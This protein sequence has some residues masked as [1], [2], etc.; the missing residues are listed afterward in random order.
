M[1]MKENSCLIKDNMNWFYSILKS[2]GTKEKEISN[3]RGLTVILSCPQ[4]PGISNPEDLEW[5]QVDEDR[6]ECRQLVW[7]PAD[8]PLHSLHP[9]HFCVQQTYGEVRISI[10]RVKGQ[11]GPLMR[12]P[13][14]PGDRR[15][16]E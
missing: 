9:D 14:Q 16:V 10:A 1:L 8:C 15:I 11:I 6:E 2:F 4:F 5:K 12:D 3:D 7:V 13:P